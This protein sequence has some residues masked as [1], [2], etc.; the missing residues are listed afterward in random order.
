VRFQFVSVAEDYDRTVAFYRDGLGLPVVFSWD[1]G[2]DRGTFFQAASGIVEVVSQSLGLRG[3]KNLGMAIQVE[4]VDAVYERCV[5]AGLRIEHPLGPRPWGT[6]EF[7]LLDPD[8][9]AVTF[10]QEPEEG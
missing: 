8:D 4:D 7:V 5:A 9:N 2:D 10:F 3:P 6:R 1:R